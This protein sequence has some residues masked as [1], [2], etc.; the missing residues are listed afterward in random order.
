VN[1]S[2]GLTAIEGRWSDENLVKYLQSPNAFAQGTTMP[3]PGI[4]DPAIIDEIVR[5]LEAL[6]VGT[7][8][9]DGA[10]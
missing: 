3:D 9:G 7:S 6:R 1:Y 2:A 4:D 5:F 10:G 8:G